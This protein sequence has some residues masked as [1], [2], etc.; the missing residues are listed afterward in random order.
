V[1][2]SPEQ[3]AGLAKAALGQS[4]IGDAAI[5]LVFLADVERSA[6]KYAQ[7]GRTLFALQDATIAAAYAQLCATALGLAS[8]WVGAF[9]DA[10]VANVLGAPAGLWPIAILPIGVP[11]E[12]PQRPPRRS[13][14]ALLLRTQAGPPH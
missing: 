12:T 11:A 8:C 2:D 9:D 3:K 13:H 4:F 14:A 5:V 6:V 7:R 1:V 10:Q